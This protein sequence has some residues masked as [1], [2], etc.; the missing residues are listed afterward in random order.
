MIAVVS[1]HALGQLAKWGEFPGTKQGD[2]CLQVLNEDFAVNGCHWTRLNEYKIPDHAPDMGTDFE[3]HQALQ[4]RKVEIG[5]YGFPTEFL[6]LDQDG[7]WKP[8]QSTRPT[9]SVRDLQKQYDDSGP[10]EDPEHPDERAE[11]EQPDERAEREHPNKR[12]R[13]NHPITGA[14]VEVTVAEA[15]PRTCFTCLGP[16][17]TVKKVP[18]LGKCVLKQVHEIG[19]QYDVAF[20]ESEEPERFWLDGDTWKTTNS[21]CD[22]RI[23]FVIE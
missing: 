12:R 3:L 19:S 10:D 13:P 1:P 2:V 6:T 11:R 16:K 8:F 18:P 4:K 17:Q 14:S 20:E 7:K 21:Q 9:V 23:H 15:Y 5:L 22:V